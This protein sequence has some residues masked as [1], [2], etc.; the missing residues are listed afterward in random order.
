LLGTTG[1]ND[2]SFDPVD[3]ADELT[4]VLFAVLADVLA[5][6]PVDDEADVLVDVEFAVLA[7]VLVDEPANVGIGVGNALPDVETG[8]DVLFDATGGPE[9]APGSSVVGK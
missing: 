1:G 2:V 4:E 7:D 5:N 9:P 8:G 6:D 3:D